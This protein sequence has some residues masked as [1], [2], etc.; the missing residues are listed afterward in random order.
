MMYS[1]KFRFIL[2][3]AASLLAYLTASA[4]IIVDHSTSNSGTGGTTTLLSGFNLNAGNTLV[5]MVTSENASNPALSHSVTFGGVS[6]TDFV[7]EHEGNQRASIF[8]AINSSTTS[9]DVSI[10]F[11]EN[12]GV[13]AVSAISLRNVDSLNDSATFG[14]PD[15][16]SYDLMY[17]G[18]SGG[19]VLAAFIDNDFN[20]TGVN[21]LI[22]GDN[23]IDEDNP[24]FLH[25][26]GQT[27]YSAGSAHAYGAIPSTSTFT[28]TF[29]IGGTSASTRNAAALISLNGTT[30]PE[31]GSFALMGL[32]LL[33][34]AALRRHSVQG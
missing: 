6:V 30:V 17:N 25:L 11:G 4:D 15:A 16:A 7:T 10:N 26:P 1:K 19:M 3:P 29:F 8:Y 22:D 24:Y 34:T 27:G 23:I 14:E 28:E 13:W 21:L 31:P 18:T 9:G 5:V 20:D 32:G 2:L 12:A 33:L